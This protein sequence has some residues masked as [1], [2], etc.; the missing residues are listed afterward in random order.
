MTEDTLQKI[1]NLDNFSKTPPSGDEE[2]SYW[3]LIEIA[4]DLNKSYCATQKLYQRHVLPEPDVRINNS[5]VWFD[6][7]YQW[8]KQDRGL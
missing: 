6:A 8:W 7:H 2:H 4:K 3:T 1:K 5:P